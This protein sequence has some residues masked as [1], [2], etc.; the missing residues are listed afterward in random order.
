[1]LL[2]V[3]SSCRKDTILTD[4]SAQLAFTQ[5]TILFDAVFTTIGSVTKHFKIRNEYNQAINITAVD[6]AS[7]TNSNFRI[8]IDGVPGVAFN[9]IEIPANDSLFVFVEATIDPTGVNTPLIVEDS[10]VF[11]TNGNEQKVWLHAW[12]QDAYFHNRE[13]IA[14]S[15]IWQADKPH[16]I[17]G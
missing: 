17:Y 5:D 6:L 10:I 16:V 13:E 9:N 11:L 12:G 15:T 8:N 4:G 14:V 2:L 3:V 7:G 1:M